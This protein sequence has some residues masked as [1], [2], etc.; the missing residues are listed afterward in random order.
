MKKSLSLLVLSLFAVLCF[1]QDSTLVNPV[2]APPF[3]SGINWAYVL[4][5]IL[6]AG[7]LFFKVLSGKI[8]QKLEQAKDLLTVLADAVQDDKI[9]ANEMTDIAQKAKELISK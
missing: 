5:L 2:S 7:V 9:D 1:G 3:W 4:N 6:G 8:K